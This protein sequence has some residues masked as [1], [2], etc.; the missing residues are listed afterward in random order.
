MAVNFKCPMKAAFFHVKG[1]PVCNI[2]L[3]LQRLL[4]NQGGLH[5]HLYI[6]LNSDIAV[7]RAYN[8]SCE[9]A[10]KYHQPPLLWSCWV[11]SR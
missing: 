7:L 1:V 3:L 2:W 6:A 11:N 8:L 10:G 5:D 4:L 9:L